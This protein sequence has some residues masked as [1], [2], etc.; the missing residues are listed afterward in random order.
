MAVPAC[1][2]P[3]TIT[4]DHGHKMTVTLQ[5]DE[6]FNWARTADGTPM[7]RRAGTDVWSAVSKEQLSQ[8][9]RK[10][11]AASK[12]TTQIDGT[13]PAQGNRRLLMLLINYADTET[14]FTQSDFN[15][16]MNAQGFGGIGSFRDYY[17][18]NSYGTLDINTTVTRWVT[19]PYSKYEY[20]SEGAP[21][22]IMDALS[23][24]DAEIDLND[25][26]NDGDGVL[27]GLA[28]IHQGAGAEASG[29]SSDIWSHSGTL[30]GITYDGVE[31][32]RYTIQPEL[33]ADTG[34]QSTI[35]VMCHE[36][37]HNLGAPDF[38]D[39]DYSYSGG[40]YCGTGLWDLMGSGAWN[41]DYGNRPAGTNAWQ[42]IQ[43]GWITPQL[44][45]SPLSVAA[46]PNATENAVA[47]RMNTTV[48]GEYFIFENRQQTGQFDQAIPGH[49]LLA[50]HVDENIINEKIYNN[51]IN[52]TFPQ[53][54]YTVCAGA[55]SDPSSDPGSYG[56][57]NTQSAPFPGSAART[58][59]NDSSTPSTRSNSGRY[60]YTGLTGIAENTD[61]TVAFQF[62]QYEVPATPRQLTATATRGVV[63]LSW[64][65]PENATPVKYNIFR[66][67]VQLTSVTTP[68]YTD[69]AIGSLTD[70]TY[71]V[72]A[73]Y[74][75]GLTSPAAMASVVI[76]SNKI[77]ALTA[78]TDGNKVNLVWDLDT[79]LTRMSDTNTQEYVRESYNS[80]SVETAHRYRAADLAV[81]KGYKLRRVAFLPLQSQREI[82]CQVTIYTVDP[83]TGV[84]T[85][86]SQRN[87]SEL[88]TMVW[89]DVV[90]TKSVEIT[91][92][93]DIVVAV[94]YTSKDGNNIQLITDVGPVLDGYGNLI[95]TDGTLPM[96]DSR[97]TGNIFMYT[98]LVPP[99]IA[100][101]HPITVD[102]AIVDHMVDATFPIG[103]A[104][105]RNGTRVGTTG[106]RLYVDAAP[107][108]THTYEVTSLYR[109]QNESVSSNTAEATVIETSIAAVTQGL[110]VYAD[111]G[112]IIVDG[113][114][115]PL[116]VT[117]ISGQN[118]VRRHCDGHVELPMPRGIYLVTCGTTTFKVAL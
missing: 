42:K 88:G 7:L 5:G 114:D 16:Y 63:S 105:Y 110:R 4:D 102:D 87:V 33:L 109:G 47:Y 19:V 92:D 107:M 51:N 1:P 96:P 18:E 23:I 78:E 98:T 8:A 48:P 93:K 12:N 39:T 69:A 100:E 83:A 70:L 13:F 62:V 32:R 28:V 115:G 41:G 40:D 58:I 79:K 85:V 72:D 36:F 64:Q 56:W 77:T 117:T 76:P 14:T 66:N 3:V 30:Y 2:R 26:D 31:L 54:V 45:D 21:R 75:D 52:A 94:K 97:L 17:L 10:A 35:G 80:S 65:A 59:F 22:L 104:I 15:N 9:A 6:H 49:G 67:N 95:S 86:A 90:L 46:M 118:G 43:L 113:Y 68:G 84:S 73:E 57:V 55:S 29:S 111:R 53:G 103:F 99:A 20:G 61:G 27:D 89:N 60:T 82:T 106:G 24:L 91:G 37:G 11:R 116:T 25:F 112:H 50:Y 71:H 34:R 74:A 44:L 81:Y 38:Y 108:G 101:Q